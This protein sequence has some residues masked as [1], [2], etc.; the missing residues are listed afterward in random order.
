MPWKFFSV[1]QWNRCVTLYKSYART[2]PTAWFRH[3][4]FFFFF[5][6]QIYSLPFF[7]LL[8]TLFLSFPPSVPWGFTE[9][10]YGINF[11]KI[12]FSKEFLS[13][14]INSNLIACIR[15]ISVKKIKFNN[16]TSET[17]KTQEDLKRRRCWAGSCHRNILEV[18]VCIC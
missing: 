14:E 7:V 8:L 15:G 13:L 9:R 10:W 12:H 11:S 3:H 17:S 1:L 18:E 2:L 6:S 4:F 5:L 16:H